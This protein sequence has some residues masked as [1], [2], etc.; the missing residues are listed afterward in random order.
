MKKESKLRDE[1]EHIYKQ[2]N[3]NLS[4]DRAFPFDNKEKNL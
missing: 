2:C 4:Q 3:L 1:I